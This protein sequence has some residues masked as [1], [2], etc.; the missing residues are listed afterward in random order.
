MA[1]PRWPSLAFTTPRTLPD[2]ASLCGRVVVLDIAFAA[3][4]LGTSFEEMTGPFLDGL[5]NR[6]AAWVDHHDHEYFDRF[7]DD[8]RF[9]LATKAEHGACPELV[10]PELVART[11]PV[12][13][14]L[15]HVDLDGL[16]AAAKWI[17]G[18]REPYAGA[19]GDARKVDTRTGTPS[20]TARLIDHA[21]RARFRDEALKHR[22]V[23]WLV[24][25]LSDR[26]H[27]AVVT[28]AAGE[29]DAMLAETE[30]L[31]GRYKVDGRVAVVDAR[32]AKGRYDKTDLLL[33]G[34][35][36]AEVAI[37]RDSGM[38]TVAAGFDSGWN[39]VTLLGLGGGMPTRV[40][41]PESRLAEAVDAINA[42]PAPRPRR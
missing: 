12:D 9:V 23:R 4:G 19:D 34:Q 27:R 40:S 13:V 29:F 7:R 31:A 6:L 26:E 22:I 41:V 10:T 32:A 30:R 3:E 21:L 28:E 25:G 20:A 17:L 42:A 38:A 2:P 36:R 24:G 11:G 39:F 16:F 33:R 5:G 37:V 15:A 35:E 14:V 1:D 8:P 18:G